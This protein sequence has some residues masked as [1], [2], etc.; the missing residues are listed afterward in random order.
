M[1]AILNSREMLIGCKRKK[2]RKK[3]RSNAWKKGTGK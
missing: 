3:E 1:K 2:E